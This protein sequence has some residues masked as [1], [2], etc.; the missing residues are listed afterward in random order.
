MRPLLITLLKQLASRYFLIMRF[1]LFS[2][3]VQL[4]LCYAPEGGLCLVFA[5]FIY[6]PGDICSTVLRVDI[7]HVQSNKAEVVGCLEAVA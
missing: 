7:Q 4:W 5:Y 3:V 2:P 1:A 6:S